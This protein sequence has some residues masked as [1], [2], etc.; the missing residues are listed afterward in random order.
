MAARRRHRIQGALECGRVIRDIVTLGVV[1]RTCGDDEPLTRLFCAAV[2]DER[3]RSQRGAAAG[4]VV[5]AFTGS[6]LT[7][8]ARAGR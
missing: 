1:G 8:A 7:A 4:A 5:E 2:D 3:D 6:M